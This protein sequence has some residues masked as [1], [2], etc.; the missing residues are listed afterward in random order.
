MIGATK[1]FP[2]FDNLYEMQQLALGHRCFYADLEDGTP[3]FELLRGEWSPIGQL[4][5]MWVMGRS[6]P[7]D[8][9]RSRT[10][11]WFYLSPR[12]QELFRTHRLTGWS[13]CPIT[14]Y[15]KA[16]EV[17]PGYAVLSITGRCGP[18]QQE[19]STPVPDH[20]R[21][22]GTPDLMGLCF[23]ESTWDGSDFFCPA[24]RNAY[25]FVTDKVKDL[26][27]ENQIEGFEFIPLS[28]ATWY[29]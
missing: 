26:F 21:R 5:A 28:A 9:A 2:G 4:T 1:S 24:G 13:A 16:G 23:D 15:D 7:E 8:I 25:K 19:R 11:T 18:V 17:C 27:Q 12:V 10:V 20:I 6:K 22:A 14:L 3:D 29:P